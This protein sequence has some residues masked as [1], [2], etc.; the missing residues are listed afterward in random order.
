[1][2]SIYRIFKVMFVS[3][4]DVYLYTIHVHCK[5]GYYYYYYTDTIHV[6]I[7]VVAGANLSPD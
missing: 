3:R 4:Y 2:Y 6:D 7:H 5:S 1:M